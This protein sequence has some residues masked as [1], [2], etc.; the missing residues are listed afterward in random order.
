MAAREAA[1]PSADSG[2]GCCAHAFVLAGM[3]LGVM[4][5]WGRDVSPHQE[6]SLAMLDQAMR[7]F[8]E[9][10]MGRAVNLTARRH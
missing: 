10:L 8:V 2:P 7:M 9:R 4:A 1:F 5:Y 3:Y 6:D